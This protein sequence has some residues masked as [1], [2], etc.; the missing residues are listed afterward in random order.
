MMSST[1]A[2]AITSCLSIAAAF[3]SVIAACATLI[4]S[5][6]QKSTALADRIRDAAKEQRE[7]PTPERR[8]QLLEQIELFRT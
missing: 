4:T 2:P 1:D 5:A 7:N 3:I 6:N 8:E